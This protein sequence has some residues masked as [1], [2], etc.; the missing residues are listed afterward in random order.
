MES[1]L[2]IV[3]KL[4]EEGY[5]AYYAG[6]WVRDYLMGNRSSDIDIATDA[7]PEEIARLFP[8]TIHVGASFGVIVVVLEGQQFEVATFREDLAYEGGRRPLAIVQSTA[9]QDAFRRDFTINGMFYDPITEVIYDYVGGQEDLKR[10]IIRTIGNPSERFQEDRLRMIRAIR[11]AKRFHFHIEHET[12]LAIQQHASTLLPAVSMERVWQELNK[13]AAYPRFD[14]ALVEMAATGLLSEIFPE[15]KSVTPHEIAKRVSS[16]SYFPEQTPTIA[17]LMELFP[18]NPL[19]DMLALCR[20]LKA[21]NEEMRFAQQLMQARALVVDEE[22]DDFTWS[23]LYAHPSGRKCLDIIAARYSEKQRSLF[24]QTHQRRSEKLEDHIHRIRH[25]TPLVTSALLKKEGIPP[26]K[27]MGRLLQEAERIAINQ[28]IEDVDTI[29]KLLKQ[30]P[31]WD[32]E[33]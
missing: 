18:E 30:S 26:G 24:L 28:H 14:E 2:H 3:K 22:T 19:N 6:G 1:A 13:M 10:R 29:L 4:K 31:H 5:I 12:Y 9:E 20:Y 32:E 17:Y 23:Q 8:N 27:K 25:R 7:S 33:L 16:F 11:F 15:L 21:S